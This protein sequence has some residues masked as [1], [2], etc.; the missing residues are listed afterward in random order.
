MKFSF[1]LENSKEFIDE[2]NRKIISDFGI[3]L[4]LPND[5]LELADKGKIKLRRFDELISGQKHKWL[6]PILGTPCYGPL[7]NFNHEHYKEDLEEVWILGGTIKLLDQS[8]LHNW[9]VN[10]GIVNNKFIYELEGSYLGDEYLMAWKNIIPGFIKSKELGW[11]GWSY[12]S[13]DP[14]DKPEK[15]T[16]ML[17]SLNHHR[18]GSCAQEL[19]KKIKE[20]FK[21]SGIG[22]RWF[23]GRSSVDDDWEKFLRSYR[24]YVI[25]NY[26]KK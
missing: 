2:T 9:V 22:M 17:I 19:Q 1:N 13:T 8:N 3:F 12:V 7:N 5:F 21:I 16:K 26:R 23:M 11:I 20:F 14:D 6:H 10:K 15:N 4:K 25:E 18:L 24:I